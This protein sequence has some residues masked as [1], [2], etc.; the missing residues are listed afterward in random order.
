MVRLLARGAGEGSRRTFGEKATSSVRTEKWVSSAVPNA[1]EIA[2]SAA[3]SARHHDASDPG[4][5]VARI[6]RVP[7]SVEKSFEPS[8][9]VHRCRI[10][11][12]P[13]SPR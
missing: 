10:A 12:T 11:W 5:I 7:A 6:E 13:I 9:E 1:V 2:T 8:A 4:V 3:S